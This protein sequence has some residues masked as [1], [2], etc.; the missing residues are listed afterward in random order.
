[1]K[2]DRGALDSAG[3]S[4]EK[5]VSKGNIYLKDCGGKKWEFQRE[6]KGQPYLDISVLRRLDSK[7]KK[8]GRNSP[9][10]K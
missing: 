3:T 5:Q 10:K 2:S 4:A 6:T 1:L 8:K 9:K 7:G